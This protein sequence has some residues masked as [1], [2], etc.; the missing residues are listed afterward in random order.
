[1]NDSQTPTYKKTT[2]VFPFQGDQVL[3]G[4]KKRGFGEGWWNGFGGKLEPGETYEASAQRETLEEVGVHIVDLVHLAD[5]HFYFEGKLQIVSKVYRCKYMG[6]PVE[7]EE[8]RPEF[9]SPDELPYDSMWPGDDAWIPKMFEAK[10][11]GPLGFK[12]YFDKNDSFL[13]IEEV[14]AETLQAE[15]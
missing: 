3:L 2:I 8:M 5:I 1:M 11:G 9:F 15:F 7:T 14:S 6:D 13:S 10:S 12:L 4:M